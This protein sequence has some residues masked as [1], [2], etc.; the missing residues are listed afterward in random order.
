MFGLSIIFPFNYTTFLTHFYMDVIKNWF[1]L[2][3]FVA[4][5]SAV[6]LGN[7]WRF[8][9]LAAKYG[10]GIFLLIYIALSVS[11]GFALMVTEISIIYAQKRLHRKFCPS[12]RNI[13]YRNRFSRRSYNCSR[14]FAFTLIV[15][16]TSV[17][18]YSCLHYL[19]PYRILCQ[20]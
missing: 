1:P 2:I 14:R 16:M 15:G 8:P 18:G 17:L 6:W 19:H 3:I 13:R 10:G 4:A 9:Y 5:G 20:D 12:D 11:F 7:I